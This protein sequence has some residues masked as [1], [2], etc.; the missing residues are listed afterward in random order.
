MKI[1]GL[2]GL[3]GV[4]LASTRIEVQSTYNKILSLE[5]PFIE[6]EPA[7]VDSC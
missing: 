6:V 3:G 4:V 7:M 1:A 2:E 5:S